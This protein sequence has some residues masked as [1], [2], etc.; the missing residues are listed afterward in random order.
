MIRAIISIRSAMCAAGAILL[1][2]SLAMGGNLPIATGPDPSV[3]GYL[4]VVPDEFGSWASTTYGG[5]GDTFN[6]SGPLTALDAAFTSGFLL[7]V[8][9]LS[10]RELLSENPSW[11]AVFPADASLSSSVTSPL[12]ASDSNGDGVDD[13]LASS[14]VVSGERRISRLS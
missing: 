13:T 3:D 11:Q 10:Q 7:F 12:V 14:F 5:G 2:S 4:A 1:S 6:P 8:P 9:G